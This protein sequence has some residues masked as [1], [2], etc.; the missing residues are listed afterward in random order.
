MI[1]ILFSNVFTKSN[2][3]KFCSFM[4]LILSSS[5]SM[6]TIS[7]V[8][9]IADSPLFHTL[10]Y[11]WETALREP[12]SCDGD[13]SFVNLS[14]E[15]LWDEH[16]WFLDRLDYKLLVPFFN[17]IELGKDENG[18]HCS[19]SFDQYY[20]FH[21][22]EV[23]IGNF[24]LPCLTK[25]DQIDA[26]YKVTNLRGKHRRSPTYYHNDVEFYYVHPDP[27]F[28]ITDIDKT[29]FVW[30]ES[31]NP[32]KIINF[33]D[34]K[35][36]NRIQTDTLQSM[37]KLLIEEE[38]DLLF[39]QQKNRSKR[40]LSINI[41][42]IIKSNS[43]SFCN[44]NQK[45][46]ENTPHKTLRRTRTKSGTKDPS[47][48]IIIPSLTRN[49]EPPNLSSKKGEEL[50]DS[51]ESLKRVQ[52]KS[53]SPRDTFIDSDGTGSAVQTA[54]S[55]SRRRRSSSALRNSNHKL[56]SGSRGGSPREE[57]P[58]SLANSV[59]SSPRSASPRDDS[60][61]IKSSIDSLDSIAS[62]SKD[63]KEEIKYTLKVILTS[64]QVNTTTIDCSNMPSH[65]NMTIVPEIKETETKDSF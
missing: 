63:S 26:F 24:K 6:E 64:G 3:I 58:R 22:R 57:S 23:T 40:N 38:F 37:E 18:N 62:G 35:L 47:P 29:F 61:L 13:L 50:K 48:R 46:E 20:V 31:Y 56:N 45:K 1:P 4:F 49:S 21:S 36:L 43:D 32:Y 5:L 8:S 14:D 54:D 7:E 33:A 42:D 2:I 65:Y 27:F 9:I 44:N 16:E 53:S 17:A 51:A 41:C 11:P 30:I 28:G 10:S 34:Q 59:E 55:A 60:L 52:I 25:I 15:D 12:T 39:I 19:R